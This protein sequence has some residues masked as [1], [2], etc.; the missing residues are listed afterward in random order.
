MKKFCENYRE[1][2]KAIKDIMQKL[3]IYRLIFEDIF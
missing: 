1:N 2:L 3:L